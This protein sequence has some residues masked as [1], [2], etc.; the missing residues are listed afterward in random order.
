MTKPAIGTISQCPPNQCCT[1]EYQSVVTG[2]NKNPKIP[3]RG[4]GKTPENQLLNNH[5]QTIVSRGRSSAIKTIRTG[6]YEKLTPRPM[7]AQWGTMP[8][9]EASLSPPSK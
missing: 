3:K 2:R 9:Q 8:H 1:A 6:I 5:K 4:D 7:S